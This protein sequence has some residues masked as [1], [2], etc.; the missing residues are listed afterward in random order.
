MTTPLLFANETKY[1]EFTITQK[2]IT[3][4]I[5]RE[6]DG[7]NVVN[8]TNST[9]T[10]NGM[11]EGDD[12]EFSGEIASI[13]TVGN[14][15]VN[16]GYTFAGDS[17]ANY[18]VTSVK[19]NIAKN[20]TWAAG[21]VV[22]ADDYTYGEIA[23]DDERDGED[24]YE[25]IL[26]HLTIT[27]GLVDLKDYL[28]GKGIDLEEKIGGE[29]IDDEEEAESSDDSEGSEDK[30]DKDDSGDEELDFDAEFGDLF[31]DEEASSDEQ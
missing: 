28:S 25:L 14:I 26:D 29:I 17:S 27:S 3:I 22:N 10:F 15:A 30:E 8:S 20:T 7:T 31:G 19:A 9:V 1:L 13:N 4:S 24:W 6:F 21:I 23:K 2:E 12:L 11:I 16:A 5:S 18:N